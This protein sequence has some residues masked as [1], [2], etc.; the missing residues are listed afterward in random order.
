MVGPKVSPYYTEP[1]II[2]LT[3]LLYLCACGNQI[4]TRRGAR[5]RR[6]VTSIAAVAA[7]R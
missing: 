7:A 6:R 2:I 4:K 1:T 5:I 3:V